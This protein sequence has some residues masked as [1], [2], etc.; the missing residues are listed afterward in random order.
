MRPM[1]IAFYHNLP[2]GGAKRVAYEQVRELSQ[3]CYEIYE[4]VLSTAD[5]NFMSLESYIRERYS[6]DV[7]PLHWFQG[8]IPFLTPYIHAFQGFRYQGT[9]NRLN[10]KIAQ[11]IDRGNFDLVLLMDCQL[12]TIPHVLQHLATPAVL[13]LNSLPINRQNEN[14][15][16][17]SRDL[18]TVFK[19]IY[20]APARISHTLRMRYID[21]RNLK[22]AKALLINS[23]FASKWMAQH[24]GVQPKVV[25]PG[26]DVTVFR[27]EGVHRR[28][29]MLAVGSLTR[30]KGYRFMLK[31]L[32]RVPANLRSKLIIAA[33][34]ID[35]AEWQAV[36]EL[37][38][39]H[40]LQIEIRKVKSEAELVRLYN[41][42]QMLLFTPVNEPL[43]LVALEA[44]ACGTPVVGIKEGGLCE[45]VLNGET[46]LLTERDPEDFAQA[47]TWMRDHPNERQHMGEVGIRYT[48][49]K[50]TWSHAVDCLET[51]FTDVLPKKVR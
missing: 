17:G 6:F 50:W 3:R 26:V 45:T 18:V 43:G 20:Y 29:F 5:A 9:V 47:V 33:N 36:L 16:N 39:L 12:T 7:Q 34:F 38:A 13:Y 19:E 14:R 11:Q 10:A 40:G 46:G 31:A 48:R 28:D 49:S 42:A 27:P 41:E 30:G 25:Y 44:M 8:R 1:R 2:S 37:A 15:S 21:L 4:F 23:H 35:N 51:V 24:Y 22:A 32:G